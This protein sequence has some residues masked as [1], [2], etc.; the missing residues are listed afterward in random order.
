M[1]KKIRKFENHSITRRLY[2]LFSLICLLFG[3]D[4]P[5][6][7]Y[8]DHSTKPTIRIN[9]QKLRKRRS[10]KGVCEG[11]SMMLLVSPW[12]KMWEN[13]SLPFTRDRKMTAQEMRETAGETPAVCRRRKSSSDRTAR[14]GLLSSQYQGLSRGRGTPA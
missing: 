1:K 11:K 12:W 7:L 13:K 6:W 10:N 14:S 8:A 9:W 4:C 3:V 2:L 5:T